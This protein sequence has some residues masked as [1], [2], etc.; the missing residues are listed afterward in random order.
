MGFSAISRNAGWSAGY[1]S[2]RTKRS[3]SVASAVSKAPAATGSILKANNGRLGSTPYQIKATNPIVSQGKT[4]TLILLDHSI[5]SKN[6]NVLRLDGPH[7]YK[8]K[9][10]PWHLNVDNKGRVP[11]PLKSMDHKALP[12]ALQKVAPYT[13]A[14]ALS[15]VSKGA[16]VVAVGVDVAR[17]GSAYRADGNRVG[18]ETVTTAASVAG[19]WAGAWAGAKVGATGGAMVGAFGGP[20]GAAVGGIVGGIGGAIA[21]SLVGSKVGEAGA[22]A[23]IRHSGWR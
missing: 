6:K 7:G 18:K 11:K 19:G 5:T 17:I 8:G 16:T 22:R 3:G 9:T 14:K 4:T 13:S 1:R 15:T 10:I 23:A 12:K 21:G 20:V 2:T